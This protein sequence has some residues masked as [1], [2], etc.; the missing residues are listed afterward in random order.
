M[1][2][3]NSTGPTYAGFLARLKMKTISAHTHCASLIL[4][5]RLCLNLEGFSLAFLLTPYYVSPLEHCRVL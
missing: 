5:V 2:S 1:I 3:S 4:G